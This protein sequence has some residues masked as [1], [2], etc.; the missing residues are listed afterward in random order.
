METK[1]MGNKI[2]EARKS[3]NMSQSQLAE[4]LF[5]SA[6]AVGKWERGESIPDIITMTRLAEIL[7]VD[8]NYFSEN[9]RSTTNKTTL[10]EIPAKNQN[11]PAGKAAKKP[12]WDMSRGNWSG[13]DFSG[14]KNLHDKFS[15]SNMQ[16]C[17]F[18]GSDLSGLL[19][20]DNHVENCDF[21]DSD[22]SNSRFQRSFLTG[23][24][25][26]N[27]LLT[28]A[29]FTASYFSDCNFSGADFSGAA[30]KS[31]GIEKSK[32]AGSIWKRTTL[33][34]SQLSDVVLEG[35]VEDC[36]FENCAFTKVTFK[37]AT[38]VNT[39]FKCKSLKR[40]S[41][42]NCQADRLTYEFL[43]NG[44]ADLSGITLISE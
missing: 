29:E 26:C 20:K 8:L 18:I 21:S 16:N 11:Q 24:Q 17:K 5:I 28:D 27:C 1:R 14:L 32:M 39:F 30:I 6:Q 23:N 31:G 42:I 41:F 10:A 3:K 7:D 2:A 13:A 36:S 37:N 33:I 4:Q 22:F 38:L 25:L 9:F 15:E 19:L 40:I 44:K 43:K 35:A 34:D 12:N